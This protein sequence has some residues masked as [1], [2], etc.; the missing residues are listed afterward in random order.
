MYCAIRLACR[1]P[2]EVA[3]L[4]EAGLK[5]LQGEGA[6]EVGGEDIGERK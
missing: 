1:E 6:A 2:G 3:R 5:C 4:R